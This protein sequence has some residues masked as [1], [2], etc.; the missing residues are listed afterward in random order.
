MEMTLDSSSM[1]LIRRQTLEKA[2]PA[3]CAAD[4]MDDLSEVK[5][6]VLARHVEDTQANVALV[7]T[8][9]EWSI[10]SV[11]RSATVDSPVKVDDR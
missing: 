11:G 5:W 3:P 6:P 4:A 9:L 10:R 8:W 1:E 2:E 7:G